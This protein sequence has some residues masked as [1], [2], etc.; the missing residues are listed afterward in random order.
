MSTVSVPSFVAEVLRQRLVLITGE[1]PGHLIFF[2][3]NHTPL[4]AIKHCVPQFP[5]AGDLMGQVN[6]ALAVLA[7]DFQ[8]G[9]KDRLAS[10]VSKILQSGGAL[11]L[12]RWVGSIDMTADRV[13]FLLAYDLEIS[14]EVVRATE[15]DSSI[16][17]KER[18]KELVLFSVSEGYMNIREK[19]GISVAK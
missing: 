3:R 5:I 2:S 12:K 19:L 14:T 18:L 15:G 1:D 8:G 13:G 9:N 6:E 16:P 10:L 11:D 4:T 7:A 17:S